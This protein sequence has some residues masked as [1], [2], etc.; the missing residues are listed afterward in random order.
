VGEPRRSDRREADQIPQVRR[1]LIQH[2][3]EQIV[4]R[5]G[6]HRDLEDEQRDRDGEDAIAEC[7]EADRPK[8]VREIRLGL[9]VGHRVKIPNGWYEVADP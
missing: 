7:L 6:G 4:G 1:P 2:R 3:A 8:G 9:D 5:I